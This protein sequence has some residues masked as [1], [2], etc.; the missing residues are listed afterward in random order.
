M[1]VASAAGQKVK[2]AAE[3]VGEGVADVAK[4]TGNVVGPL[5]TFQCNHFVL[6]KIGKG[7]ENAG[8]AIQSE[9]HPEERLAESVKEKTEQFREGT[10]EFRENAKQQRE[11]QE[12][13]GN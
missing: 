13:Q 10:E 1:N 11:Q 7:L 9:D 12:A 8:Q 3:T 6:S 4:G 2:G 5:K